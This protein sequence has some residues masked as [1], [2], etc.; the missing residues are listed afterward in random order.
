MYEYQ[1]SFHNQRVDEFFELVDLGE[2]NMFLLRSRRPVSKQVFRDY[3]E[4]LR[5]DTL[6]AEIYGYGMPEDRR[7]HTLE[8]HYGL[9]IESMGA[10]W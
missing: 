10:A 7:L 5:D 4:H 8:N 3:C 6:P 2:P 1:Y 9:S